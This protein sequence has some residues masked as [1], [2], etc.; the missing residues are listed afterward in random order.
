MR[1]TG[2]KVDM[3]YTP[4]GFTAFSDRQ[5]GIHYLTEVKVLFNSRIITMSQINRS[6]CYKQA[7]RLYVNLVQGEGEYL[8]MCFCIMQYA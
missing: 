4:H 7:K 2:L 8:G 5:G 3:G 6:K 1:D